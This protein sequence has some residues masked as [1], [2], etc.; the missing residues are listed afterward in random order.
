LS[1]GGGFTGALTGTISSLFPKLSVA[2]EQ[3]EARVLE[4]ASMSV[5]SGDPVNFHSGGEYA[6]PTAQ[7]TGAVTITYKK[8]GVISNITPIVQGDRITMSMNIEV[9]APAGTSPG[10]GM[11]FVTSNIST[12]Q[13]CESGDSVVIGGLVSQRDAKLFDQLPE[14]ASGAIVQLYKSEAFRRQN[15]QFVMFVTPVTLEGGAVDGNQEV[16]GIVEERFMEYE[17]DKR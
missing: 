4:T 2:K 1:D 10:G 12:V 3:G 5:R 13:W 7:G 8:Y 14:G 15:S 17:P 16:M 6:I 9:S 11:N